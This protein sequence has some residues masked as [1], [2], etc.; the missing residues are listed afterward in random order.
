MQVFSFLA[1]RAPGGLRGFVCAARDVATASF[2]SWDFY[3]CSKTGWDTLARDAVTAPPTPF[4]ARRRGWSNFN[5]NNEPDLT[6]LPGP[7]DNFPGGW[8]WWEDF[9]RDPLGAEAEA[10]AKAA[11][12]EAAALEKKKK[13]QQRQA[14]TRRRAQKETVD[15]SEGESEGEAGPQEDK[16]EGTRQQQQL[17]APRKAPSSKELLAALKLMDLRVRLPGTPVPA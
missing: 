8:Q 5:F 12:R 16:E 2:V 1:Q 4:G 9:L 10:A 11:K 6:D 15:E 7:A 3:R 17:P 14:T 13:T